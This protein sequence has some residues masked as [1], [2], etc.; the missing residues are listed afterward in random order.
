MVKNIVITE[1]EARM[2]NAPV[3]KQGDLS[4]YTDEAIAERAALRNS[5]RLIAVLEKVNCVEMLYLYCHSI[6]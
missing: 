2:G 5:S 4:N 3:W 6:G 1:K